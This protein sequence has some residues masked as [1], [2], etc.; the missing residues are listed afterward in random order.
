MEREVPVTTT[1]APA[2]MHRCM[3]GDGALSFQGHSPNPICH[4][5][6]DALEECMEDAS[7]WHRNLHRACSSTA[8]GQ[9]RVRGGIDQARRPRRSACR[10]AKMRPQGIALRCRAFV[11]V[12]Q[13]AKVRNLDDCS[14][15]S[16]PADHADIVCRV[17]N[18]SS[19][20]CSGPDS[21]CCG[22][23]GALP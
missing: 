8:A 2:L 16:R 17:L 20:D 22:S 10:S 6:G 12:M 13:A 15:H 14:R 5:T 3:T 9:R 21:P 18:E 4:A 23:V 7:N 19:T 11:T 1:G